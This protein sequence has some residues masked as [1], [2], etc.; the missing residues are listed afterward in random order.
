[1]ATLKEL[2][3]AI[4][5]HFDVEHVFDP[6]SMLTVYSGWDTP[7][8]RP[9]AKT[10]RMLNS[11]AAYLILDTLVFCSF[12]YAQAFDS[13]FSR[14]REVYA[15]SSFSKRQVLNY[16]DLAGLLDEA[17]AIGVRR[18]LIFHPVETAEDVCIHLPPEGAGSSPVT[19]TYS[20]AIGEI[21]SPLPAEPEALGYTEEDFK[22]GRA[23]YLICPLDERLGAEI[24]DLTDSVQVHGAFDAIKY[25]C[26]DAECMAAPVAVPSPARG[27][28]SDVM[29][30]AA[31]QL[32]RQ[33]IVK[34][35]AEA[36]AADSLDLH[37]R[38]CATD[39]I[40]FPAAKSHDTDT[41]SGYRFLQRVLGDD[42]P[43]F[44]SLDDL[45]ALYCYLICRAAHAGLRK[46]LC[47]RLENAF[48]L[49]GYYRPWFGWGWLPLPATPRPA[50]PI[51]SGCCLRVINSVREG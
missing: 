39:D 25:R 44:E 9:V 26:T 33:F 15:S 29:Y 22:Q 12:D 34:I 23:V 50:A 2:S 11:T 41:F 4:R 24:T 16:G 30:D 20:S 43:D 38:A 45:L 36:A 19:G 1:M 3:T 6:C 10:S 46:N 13:I 47:W 7:T 5:T 37:R 35:I 48:R 14:L 8:G 49:V 18:V 40:T 28:R 27:E 42:C 51:E 32:A 17:S 31:L 21:V